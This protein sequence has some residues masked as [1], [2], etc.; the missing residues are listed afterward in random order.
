[1][2]GSGIVAETVVLNERAVPIVAATQRCHQDRNAANTAYVA[3]EALQVRGE[4][5]LG[6]RVDRRSRFLVVVP[7][8]DEVVLAML[9]K[10]LRPKAFIDVALCASTVAREINAG[11]IRCQ[12]RAEARPPATFFSNG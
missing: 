11:D 5:G 3:D 12:R 1:M 4:G 8:L 2:H 9:C 6:I 10:S 7:E